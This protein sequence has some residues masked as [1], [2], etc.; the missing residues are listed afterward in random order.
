MKIINVNPEDGAWY[1][2]VCENGDTVAGGYCARR[3]DAINDRSV[4][5]ELHC[6]EYLELIVDIDCSSF[7]YGDQSGKWYVG[8]PVRIEWDDPNP[9]ENWEDVET[10]LLQYL[11]C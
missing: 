8:S 10:E 1:W 6:Q 7:E 5:L 4:W 3:M 9:P 11:A 2:S